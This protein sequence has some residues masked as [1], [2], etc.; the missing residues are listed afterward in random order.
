[1]S[2]PAPPSDVVVDDGALASL[3]AEVARED[4][5]GF[6]TEF[7]TERTYVPELALI[8]IAWADKVALVD[9][10]AVD[11]APLAEVF[12]GPGVAVAHA[13][14]QD[15]DVLMAA[16]GAVPATVFDTQIVAGFLG[17]STPSLSRLVDAMLGVSLPKA[18]RLSDWLERPMSDRQISYAMSDVAHLLALR[19]VLSERLLALGRLDWAL[20]E[21]DQVLS[22]RTP[23]ARVPEEAW[24]RLGDIR[25]MSRRSRAVA[26]EVAAWRERT[27]A[28]TNRPRR[29]VL[30]DL[31]LLAI[32]QRPP[33]NADEL[34]RT[35]GVDGRHLAQGRAAEIL[36]AVR[37]G[38]DLPT[39]QVRMPAEGRDA[40]APPGAVAVCSG[41]VRQIADDLDFDQALLATRAD[42]SQLLTHEPS[43]LD[44]GWRRAIVGD[45]LRRLIAGEVA[46]AFDRRGHLVLEERSHRP[47]ESAGPG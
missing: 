19:T 18:D 10:L 15:L 39:D 4:A 24:W 12:G 3:V 9:P 46:A 7:H 8:Q 31:G 23:P 37:R 35:R 47:V 6:D 16:C 29:Q 42:I 32:S 13:S 14:T 28:E 22:D 43:R 45:P 20:D 11:P 17:M 36:G 1:V 26:Q 2:A 38:L 33:H 5:Y 41:L 44:D 25:S 40:Q 30:S 27:A 21:C 34:R